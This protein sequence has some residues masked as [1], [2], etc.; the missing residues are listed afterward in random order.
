MIRKGAN[1]RRLEVFIEANRETFVEG[2]PIERVHRTMKLMHI[3]TLQKHYFFGFSVR[4][5]E[6]GIL[7]G[8]LKL[9]KV[10]IAL[11]DNWSFNSHFEYPTVPPT[12]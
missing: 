4:N 7:L 9:L 6:N 3:S 5:P 2:E 12:E 8:N 10:S 1:S 11:K